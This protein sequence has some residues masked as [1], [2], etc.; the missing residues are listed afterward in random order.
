MKALILAAGRGSRMN[1]QTANRPKCLINVQGKS[2]LDWQIEAI[3]AAGINEIAI[4]TG[5][6]HELISPPGLQM[7]HNPQWQETN[8]VA[9]LACG[10][11]WLETE[12]CIVSYSDIFYSADVVRLL[13]SS[14]DSHLAITYHTDW[15][16]IWTK[17]FGNPL[18]DAESF[19][20]NPDGLVVEIGGKPKS[21]SEIH[22]QY[23]GLL[24]IAPK[25]WHEIENVRRGLVAEDRNKISMTEILQKVIERGIIEISALPFGGFWGEIDSEKDLEIYNETQKN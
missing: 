24:L 15:L 19:R 16:N 23:M 14:I 21:T 5:Y 10:H 20:V 13:L 6:H 22:G 11:E 8:M 18:I 2:L 4:V 25:G 9:S 3:Q 12:I 17:R 7:F 1:S